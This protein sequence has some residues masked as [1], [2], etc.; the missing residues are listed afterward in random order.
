MVDCS[1]GPVQVARGWLRSEVVPQREAPAA[2]CPVEP[3]FL[4]AV[5]IGPMTRL[6]A[7][8]FAHGDDHGFAYADGREWAAE[9]VAFACCRA[10]SPEKAP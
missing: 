7:A 1:S 4:R 2:E 8:L 10:D 5:Q 3:G 6:L 9:S